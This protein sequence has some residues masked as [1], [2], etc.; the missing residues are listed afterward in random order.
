[1]AKKVTTTQN[2]SPFE[3]QILR[4]G[5]DLGSSGVKL[6][7]E[8]N[9]KIETII[10]DSILA[11][12]QERNL[13]QYGR[14]VM[15]K[16]LGYQNGHNGNT[17]D[18][19]KHKGVSNAVGAGA[20]KFINP[21]QPIAKERFF[22]GSDL[23]KLLLVAISKINPTIGQKISIT[24]SLPVNVM[25]DEDEDLLKQSIK[26]WLLGA[27]RFEV[28]GNLYEIEIVAFEIASQPVHAVVGM[29]MNRE[30]EWI[31]QININAP[32]NLIDV[33]GYSVDLTVI[34]ALEVDYQRTKGKELGFY[35]AA[36]NLAEVLDDLYRVEFSSFEAAKLLRAYAE[37]QTAEIT[38]DNMF[39]SVHDETAKEFDGMATQ[40]LEFIR[41]V[42]PPAN[43]KQA[44]KV[45]VGGPAGLEMLAKRF[46]NEFG[47][48]IVNPDRF[49]SAKGALLSEIWNSEG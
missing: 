2:E 41:K 49:L 32:I 12:T 23:R 36:N 33:G 6:A 40:M 48:V 16:M 37:G 46:R 39:Y 42:I 5:C 47:S 15:K 30:G 38:V 24:L 9:G 27:H 43:S 14:M 44:V 26:Q 45:L 25:R 13:G 19:I 35:V 22:D 10:I 34:K 1:M 11:T 4:I 17:P 8:L 18:I 28:N 29:C 7:Y 20:E 31:S 3:G 21:Y